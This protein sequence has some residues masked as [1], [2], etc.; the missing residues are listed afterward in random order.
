MKLDKTNR[1]FGH[2]D[3]KCK[4]NMPFYIRQSSGD[5]KDVWLGIELFDKRPDETPETMPFN[6][7]NKGH[8]VILINDEIWKQIKKARKLVRN[9]K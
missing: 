4:Y 3:L 5:M 1:G 6:A 7:T 2:I 9:N 8:A